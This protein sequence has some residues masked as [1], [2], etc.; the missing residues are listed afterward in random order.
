ML[1]HQRRGHF[2]RIYPTKNSDYYDC[3]LSQSRQTQQ[4][5]YYA[6]YSD[7]FNSF[8]DLRQSSNFLNYERL[9]NQLMQRE[10]LMAGHSATT[11][12]KPSPK[13]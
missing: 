2:V 10:R 5:L 11:K 7:C 8:K 3:F 13:D 12:N 9:V 4:Q 6:L 1:E